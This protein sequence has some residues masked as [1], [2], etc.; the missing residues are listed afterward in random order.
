MKVLKLSL[1]MMLVS[2][3]VGLAGAQT[4]KATVVK[5]PV[6]QMALSKTKTKM[7]TVAVYMKGKPTM[8]CCA[9]C[10]MPAAVTTKPKKK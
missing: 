6:C 10:K 8:Y 3:V 1:A 5:C 2:S 4:K 9:G 7:N